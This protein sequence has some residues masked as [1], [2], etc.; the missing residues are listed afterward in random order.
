MP[1]LVAEPG[2][3]MTTAT[4]PASAIASAVPRT[5]PIRSQP[6]TADA[7]VTIAG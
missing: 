4:M 1:P 2:P 7:A 5:R 3:P 6:S